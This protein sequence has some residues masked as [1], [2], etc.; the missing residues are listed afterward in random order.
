MMGLKILRPDLGGFGAPERVS[1]VLACDGDHGKPVRPIWMR[2]GIS[3]DEINAQL[4][5]EGWHIRSFEQVFCPGCWRHRN[6]EVG[7]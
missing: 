4:E 1:F 6:G 5:A 3:Y 2:T 7:L